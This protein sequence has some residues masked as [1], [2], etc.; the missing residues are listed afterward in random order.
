MGDNH[1]FPNFSWRY[2]KSQ[3]LSE[4]WFLVYCGSCL[5]CGHRFPFRENN[6][7]ENSWMHTKIRPKDGIYMC[8]LHISHTAAA[9][10]MSSIPPM[11]STLS[12]CLIRTDQNC[13]SVTHIIQTSP[14]PLELF[15]LMCPETIKHCMPLSHNHSVSNQNTQ[16][17]SLFITCC[18]VWKIV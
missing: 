1:S 7:V 12:F 2:Q 17:Y 13:G 11:C 4:T 5:A 16:A 6:D 9:V 3:T 18:K 8:S 10:L 14:S 15:F